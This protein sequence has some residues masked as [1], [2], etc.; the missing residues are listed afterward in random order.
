M[1][2]TYSSEGTTTQTVDME[3]RVR[4]ALHE[5]GHLL[6]NCIS[7]HGFRFLKLYLTHNNGFTFHQIPEG[8]TME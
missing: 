3:L 6:G 7:P 4:I 1:V 2:S 5:V 8:L